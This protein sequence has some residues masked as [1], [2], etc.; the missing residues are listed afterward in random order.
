MSI[1]KVFIYQRLGVSSWKQEFFPL[2]GS[3]DYS[4]AFFGWSV[5]LG[6]S[7]STGASVGGTV[8]CAVGAYQ[9]L[10]KQEG[11]QRSV[12]AVYMFLQVG[13]TAVCDGYM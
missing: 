10:H 2:T 1:G 6:G 8:S 5:S 9:T 12:G 3:E 11:Q 7:G 4:N 13:V